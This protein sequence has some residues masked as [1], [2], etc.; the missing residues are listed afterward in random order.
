MDKDSHLIYEAYQ[1]STWEGWGDITSE[2]RNQL[3]LVIKKYTDYISKI[4]SPSLAKIKLHYLE[5]FSE[6]IDE[7][8]PN[9]AAKILTRLSMEE[10]LSLTDYVERYTDA[11]KAMT[12]LFY[13]CHKKIKPFEIKKPEITLKGTAQ[14]VQG[15]KEYNTDVSIDGILDGSPKINL[16][17]GYYSLDDDFYERF[18]K[19]GAKLCVDAGQNVYVVNISEDLAQVKIAI[20]QYLKNQNLNESLLMEMPQITQQGK[21]VLADNQPLKGLSVE[22]VRGN[23]VVLREERG[24]F[25][26]AAGWTIAYFMDSEESAQKMKKGE[27][28]YLTINDRIQFQFNSAP[29]TDVWTK[30]KRDNRGHEHILGIV[31]GITNENEIYIDKMS[32][33]AQ[34]RKNSI[35]SKLISVLKQ[36]FPNAK[37]NFSGPTKQGASFIKKYT[38]K[39]W[40]PAHGETQ[41]F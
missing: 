13:K 12:F 9:N 7:T 38:G 3:K 34:F 28:D 14:T 19:A 15:N 32:V 16:G 25:M 30:K 36:T 20:E 1:E 40:E 41:E 17:Y 26:F 22:N 39:Q 35:T 27:F 24:N 8:D 23:I 10:R 2:E 21:T 18:G 5:K 6:A 11:E 31:Q 33:R 4:Y 29:I 37:V